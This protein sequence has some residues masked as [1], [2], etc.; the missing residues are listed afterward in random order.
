MD[1]PDG[2]IAGLTSVGG[3]VGAGGALL[4][5]MWWKKRTEAI[6]KSLGEGKKTESDPPT[7]VRMAGTHPQTEVETL[8]EL[9]KDATARLE[10]RHDE[11]LAMHRETVAALS[12]V[13]S[14]LDRNTDAQD[15]LLEELRAFLRSGKR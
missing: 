14:K 12:A 4:A 2:L 7:K 13:G 5:Q 15:A 1:I 6:T 10:K 3:V 11:T 9:L 8:R